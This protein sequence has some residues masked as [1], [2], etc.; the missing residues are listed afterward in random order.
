[1]SDAA[2]LI[3]DRNLQN[4]KAEFPV[5]Q[6]RTHGNSAGFVWFS[7]VWVS[8]SYGGVFSAPVGSGHTN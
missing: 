1:M 6:S 7:V 5:Y 4:L 3:F 8:G 2:V